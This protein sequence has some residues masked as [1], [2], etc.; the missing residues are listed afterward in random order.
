MRERVSMRWGEIEYFRAKID[1]QQHNKLQFHTCD[2]HKNDSRKWTLSRTS[3][4][5]KQYI[6]Y[7][8]IRIHCNTWNNFHCFI[9]NFCWCWSHW[10]YRTV[11]LMLLVLLLLLLLSLLL[12][13]GCSFTN[14]YTMEMSGRNK[15]REEKN[16][17]IYSHG[18]KSKKNVQNKYYNTEREKDVRPE[19]KREWQR[20]REEK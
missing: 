11:L 20:G 2:W 17:Y 1:D 8:H 18:M 15:S 3:K 7:I 4:D 9:S 10:Y 12:L 5:P 13:H 6:A 16:T 14:I 19:I